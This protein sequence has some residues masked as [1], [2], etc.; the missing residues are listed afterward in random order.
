MSQWARVAQ[1]LADLHVQDEDGRDTVAARLVNAGR[2]ALPITGVGLSW[3]TDQGPG[4]ML[5]ATDEGARRMEELQF[6]LGE[7]PCIDSSRSGR[8]VL[9][10]D[11][12]RTAPALW[13]AF[14]A[15]ALEAGI[16]A[17][18]AFP[19]QVGAVRVGVFDL[20]RDQVGGLAEADLSMAMAYADA[21]T[22]VLLQLQAET[23]SGELHPKVAES[24]YDRAEVH[25]A[26]GMISVQLGVPVEDAM[27]V[28]RART[29]ASDR[30]ILDVAHDVVTRKLRFDNE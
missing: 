9:Q 21:A 30:S 7:G 29:F 10:P 26:A 28:L 5:A 24:L 13:P 12:A 3:M 16:A 14:S 2:H 4:A 18:F 6:S 23:R 20:Y 22:A 11:L 27:T 17:I 8:P 25:Q 19:L 1:I 15:L